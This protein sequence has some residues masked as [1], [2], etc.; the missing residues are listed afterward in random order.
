[1][2]QGEQQGEQRE[3]VYGRPF[4]AGRSGNPSG[5]VSKAEQE[6][7]LRAKVRE[8]ARPFGGL[9][10]LG[11]LERVRLTQA[12]RLLL[13]TRR[14]SVEDAIRY[15]NAIERLLSSVEASR[16]G[17]AREAPGEFSRLLLTQEI[18]R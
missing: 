15:A 6:R 5:S 18:G 3:R 14:R 9:G 13:D 17:H 11:V 4:P 10:V 16:G 12:A 1:M 8:L 2:Q 7:R